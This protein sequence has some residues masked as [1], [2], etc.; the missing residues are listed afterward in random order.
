MASKMLRRSGVAVGLVAE[1]LGWKPDWICQVGVGLYHKEID[2]FVEEWKLGSE[3]IVGF[4]AN[5][6]VFKRVMGSYPGTLVGMAVS[7]KPGMSAL[8]AH[9]RHK[10][11]S[12]LKGL[13]GGN[14]VSMVDCITLDEMF[15]PMTQ[16]LK[17]CLLWLD[18][19]GSE[20]DVLRGAKDFIG[21]V[22]A[23]NV[24]MTSKPNGDGWAD[25][26]DVH[27]FLE[28]LGFWL[29]WVHT[30]RVTAGQYDAIYVRGE[31]FKPE[32]C[33]SVH[34]QMRWRNR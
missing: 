3:S 19:E 23:I 14:V 29:Q 20:L 6:A 33:C 26:V 4:E 5:P 32:Y 25:P 2:V 34:E 17:N 27:V 22:N 24:E 15:S 9:P 16:D 1:L 8:R 31:L 21:N 12:T 11:G 18:C 30:Q 10:D 13:D 7:G 28:P